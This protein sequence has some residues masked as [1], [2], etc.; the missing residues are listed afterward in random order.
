MHLQNPF[1]SLLKVFFYDQISRRFVVGVWLGL[2]FSIAV[3]LSTIGL[4]D[5]FDYSLKKGLK[6]SLG[7]LSFYSHDG[8]FHFNPKW[9]SQFKQWGVK[10]IAPHIQTEAFVVKEGLSRG[11]SIRGVNSENFSQV[12][13]LKV[14]LGPGEAIIGKELA[15]T[16]RLQKGDSII[17]ALARGNRGVGELPLLKRY[18]IKSI[19]QHQIYQKDLRL[20]YV[21]LE[22][23][24]DLIGSQGKVNIVAL[25]LFDAQVRRET[26]GRQIKLIEDF[27]FQL[28]DI[29]GFDYSIKPYWSDFETLLEAVEIEKLT[30]GLILQIIV[31]ISIF[32]VL[33]FIVFLNEKRARELF[34]FR[35][36]GLSQKKIFAVWLKLV[37]LLWLASCLL[38]IGMVGF[39]DW[40]LSHW[41]L[42]QLPRDIYYLGHLEFVISLKNYLLVFFLAL[43]WLVFFSFVAFWRL[44]GK[45]ILHGLRKEFC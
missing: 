25:K 44:R 4:M 17:L 19:I 11:V 41:S 24:M 3:I 21:N 9:E 32:N 8:F 28:E 1:W 13:N 26:Q 37:L 12:T 6:H 14:D 16:F 39:F 27:I 23:L 22:E 33:A 20:V 40:A 10:G 7:D 34:L 43:C 5:G 36:L 15:K 38:S 2:S 18:R 30:I 42:L 31:I 35:A 45:F 29:L